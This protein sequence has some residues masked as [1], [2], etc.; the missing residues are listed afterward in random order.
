M[1]DAELI[2]D[3]NVE[4]DR[5]APENV[6]VLLD[7][8]TLRDGLQSPS[9]R[10]PDIEAKIRILHYQAEVGVTCA[11]IG[12]PGAGPRIASEV[13]RLAREISV[14]G[15]PILP[16]CA[17]RTLKVD[18]DPIIEASQE[19]GLA[20]EAALF[21]G[22]SHIRQYAENWTVDH[23]MQH[24]EEAVAYAAEHN[25]PVMFVT[26][27]TTRARPDTLRRLYTCAIEA[28]ATRICVADTVGH[29][30]PDGVSNL[31]GFVR[32]VVKESARPVH[33][34]W[35]GHNDR[36]LGLA[37]A[38]A[39]VC[40]GA[41]R[42]HGTVLGIGERVGNTAIDQLLVNFRLLGWI[43]ND[44]RALGP[45]CDFVSSVTGVPV[46]S[47]YPVFGADAFR[48]AT[49]VHAAAVIKAMAKGDEWLANRVYSG[50]PADYFG[51][52]QS[53][54]LGPMSGQSNVVWWLKSHDISPE[55][56]LVALLFTHCKRASRVLLEREIRE[57][58]TQ[59]QA[60]NARAVDEDD[61]ERQRSATWA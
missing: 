61:Q 7:D 14:K 51:R 42:I 48:T 55:S 33:I 31:I 52:H 19:A 29:A 50:V 10:T 9:V 11:N 30:T 38:L 58:V 17:A 36:G 54:E 46:P 20:I 47:N 18:I 15:L 8:E 24:S 57:I 45:Y 59:W 49:G 53:I 3:W 35:H 60:Q 40:A 43:N 41:D 34:D 16:N 1:R 12:L 21:I 25:L 4:G 23:L 2:Y 56:D 26:E 22:S 39:A 6:T 13:T 37:N 44:L 32:D 27:D 28:G 5:R